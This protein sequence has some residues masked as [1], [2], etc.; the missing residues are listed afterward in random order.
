MI[1]S[2]S[3]NG[4]DHVYSIDKRHFLFFLPVEGTFSESELEI[5]KGKK[6]PHIL[7]TQ[8]PQSGAEKTGLKAPSEVTLNSLS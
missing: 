3:E 8:L 1:D 2:S 7:Y 4:R 6:N 5:E